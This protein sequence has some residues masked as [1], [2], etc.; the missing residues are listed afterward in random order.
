MGNP[1][2][3]GQYPEQDLRLPKGEVHI[4]KLRPEP[5]ADLADYSRLL[6]S[7]ERERA[8][9]FRVV[10]LRHNFV[11][12]HGRMRLILGVYAGL[13]PEALVFAVNKFGKPELV[14]AGA[15]GPRG[16]LRFNLSHTEGLTLLAVCLDADLGV[17]V[18]AVRSMS[19]LEEIARSHFSTLENAALRA[20]EPDERQKAFFRCWTRKEAFLKAHGR[21]L[22]I[23]LDSFAV[24]IADE[25]FP[26][27]LECSW[28]PE[29][30]GRWAIFS[31]APGPEFAGALAI[32]R[33]AWRIRWFDWA[34]NP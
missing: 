30:I 10:L 24:S 21:G 6:G 26:V 4:W 8:G 22:S 31:L 29:E 19:D 23:P 34:G 17:D 28:N 3:D 27:L 15:T 18:E 5:E 12:D 20:V 9:R 2:I 25:D 11:V 14:D 32:Q 1:L 33:G 7:G 13:A 16:H